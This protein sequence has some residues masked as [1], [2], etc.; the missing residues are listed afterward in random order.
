MS[1]IMVIFTIHLTTNTNVIYT[2]KQKRYIDVK[3]GK[4]FLHVR[5][6]GY[7]Y[8]TI[9]KLNIMKATLHI[10]IND[11]LFLIEEQDNCFSVNVNFL[12]Y[13][14]QYKNA[15]EDIYLIEK[16]ENM[17]LFSQKELN[18]YKKELKKRNKLDSTIVSIQIEAGIINLNFIT[19]T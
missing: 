15:N 8:Y 7:I 16:D 1:E 13:K 19:K 6:N 5:N 3:D 14:R 17:F 9:K 18:I 2:R 10:D 12:V 11:S 4:T